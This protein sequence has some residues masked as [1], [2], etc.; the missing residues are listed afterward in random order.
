MW[1]SIILALISYFSTKKSGGS[2]TEALTAAA[3]VGGGSY[4]VANNTA[5]GQKNLAAF[6]NYVS[7]GS[8]GVPV[9]DKAGNP[10]IDPATGQPMVSYSSTQAGT[11]IGDVLKSWGGA[12]TA[13]VIGT[14]AAA[15]N[16]DF[17]STLMKN[18]PLVI[19]AGLLLV[20]LK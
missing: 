9:V 7:P 6:D 2:N 5:W 10:V 3:L 11:G 4:Y 15:T 20:V 1:L 16:G 8:V 18:L 14:T 19:G 12:G 17:M 13:T